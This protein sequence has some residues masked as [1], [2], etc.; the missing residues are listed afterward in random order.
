MKQ[1]CRRKKGEGISVRV[2]AEIADL[3]PGFLEN[4]H[5]DV[6][7][8]REALA[9]SDYEAIRILGHTMKG[10]G[11]GYGFDGITDMGRSLE[12]AAKEREAE[13]IRR[14][15][16]ELRSYLECVEVIYE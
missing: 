11:G 9:K 5:K 12:N 13:E 4:R 8:L 10:A 6:E 14:W 1:N 7:T 3:I 2:D 16:D 15:V